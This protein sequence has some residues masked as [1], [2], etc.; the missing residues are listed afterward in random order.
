MVLVLGKEEEKHKNI[1]KK[2]KQTMTNRTYL[3]T[4]TI[5]HIYSHIIT[6][7][8]NLRAQLN[9]LLFKKGD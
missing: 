1:K 7:S 5:I 4:H 9:S 6:E 8:F 2:T 3:E